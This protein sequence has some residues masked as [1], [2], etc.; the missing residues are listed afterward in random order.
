MSPEDTSI[1]HDLLSVAIGLELEIVRSETVP[2]T[3]D[4]LAMTIECRIDEDDVEILAFPILYALGLLSFLD[5]RP[6]GASELYYEEKD[7]FTAADL[8]RHVS[9][10]NGALHMYVDYLRGRM[11]KSDV[12]IHA[13]GRILIQTVNRDLGPDRW[14]RRLQGKSHIRLVPPPG[15]APDSP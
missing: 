6:R 11:L 7:S 1:E 14:L 8:L 4:D 2:T 12:T 13:D 10:R 5:G 9:F 15:P 3:S